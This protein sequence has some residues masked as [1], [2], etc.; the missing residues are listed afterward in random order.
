MLMKSDMRSPIAEKMAFV[1]FIYKGDRT[2]PPV[3]EL[4]RKSE[5]TDEEIEAI[6][7][8]WKEAPPIA[9]FENLL[10]AS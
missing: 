6:E 2:L 1:P 9:E 10:D 5:P 7:Q 4:Y 3:A 8:E